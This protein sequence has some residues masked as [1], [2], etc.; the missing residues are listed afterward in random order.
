[1]GRPF[2][3]GVQ[4]VATES[5]QSW[6]DVSRR[7][8]DHGYALLMTA[9]HLSDG[10]LPPLMP[11]LTAAEA[12]PGLRVG[13]LV[14]NND[15][16]H[17]SLLARE[18]ATIDLL[19]DGR[20]E[21]GLGAGHAWTEY[22]RNGLRFDPPGTRVSRLGESVEILRGLLD[23]ETV[24]YHGD[25]YRIEA[26]TCYPSPSQ[27]RVPILV[28]GG[29]R[30]V[31]GIAARHADIV[32]FTGLGTVR[33]DNPN[34]AQVTGFPTAAVDEQIDWVRSR[35][36]GR[37]ELPEFQALVQAVVIT[38]KPE[39]RADKMTSA[40]PFSALSPGELLVTPYLMIGSIDGLV[41]KLLAARDRWGFS[42]YTIRSNAMDA[43]APVVAAL[44]G[45]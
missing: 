4:A 30:R 39:E 19:T 27:S 7:A 26:E 17:P 32:G 41:D 44:T 34:F 18:A 15:F 3:F 21:I 10:C 31:L 20:L 40:G 9:D 36:A 5:R 16:R 2:R 12:A 11:L 23:G 8:A 43:F 33:Q 1:M 22:E 38:D 25:H 14:L 24:T 28:G 42:H 35:A 29:G 45:R 13:T 37:S 6:I